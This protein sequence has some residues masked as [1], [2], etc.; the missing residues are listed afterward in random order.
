MKIILAFVCTTDLG[1]SPESIA[2]VT[3]LKNLATTEA[4]TYYR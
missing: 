4:E 3:F 1:D 2:V